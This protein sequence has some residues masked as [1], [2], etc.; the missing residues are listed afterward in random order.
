MNSYR[1]QLVNLLKQIS[2]VFILYSLCRILFYYFNRSY[3]QDISYSELGTVL[4]FGLRFDA[5]SIAAT[6]AVYI[7]MCSLPFKFYYST[8]YKKTNSFVFILT[9]SIAL[10][11]NFID[12]AYFP[13]TQKRTTYDLGNFIFGGQTEFSK[14][15]PHFLAEYWFIVLLYSI[16]VFVLIKVHFKIKKNEIQEE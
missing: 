11:L 12:F 8:W 5:F 16:I 9:N 2:F 1:S 7:L 3:F 14:L 15:I 4:F 13:F 6:N 10:S